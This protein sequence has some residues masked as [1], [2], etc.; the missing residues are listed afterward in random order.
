MMKIAKLFKKLKNFL[1]MDEKTQSEESTK[2]EKLE[3]SLSEK[4]VS[5]KEKIRDS[6]NKQKKQS[7]IEELEMLIKLSEELQKTT[8]NHTD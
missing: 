4:I 1:E 8:I 2:K 6:D 5:M 3:S 7:M